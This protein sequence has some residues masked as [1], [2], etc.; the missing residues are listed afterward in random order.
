MSSKTIT[1]TTFNDFDQRKNDITGL[2]APGLL[3]KWPV[4]GISM[5]IFGSLVFG[6]LTYNLYVHGPLLAWDRAIANTLPAIGLQSPP[7]VK[8]IMVAGFYTGKEV[9]TVLT[10]LF[11]LYFLYKRYWQELAMM[12]IGWIGS[13]L[14]FNALSMLIGRARPPTQI[15]IIVNIPGFP[16]G[17]AVSVVVFYGLMAYLLAPKMPSAVWNV[18]VVA[19]ALLIIGFVGFSRIFTGGHY[20]TDILAGYAVGIAWSGVVYTLIE[21][22]FQKRRSRNVKKE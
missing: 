4:I 9:V 18:V 11:S 12:A 10:I 5:F 14:F 19:A 7:F 6:A 16:S 17:H 15:W 3:A 20:L 8:D 2:R 13:A 21:N 22:Y 1:A